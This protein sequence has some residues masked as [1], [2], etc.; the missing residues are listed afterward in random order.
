MNQIYSLAHRIIYLLQRT[1]CLYGN[2]VEPSDVRP[3]PPVNVYCMVC[4]KYLYT[5]YDSKV[6][7]VLQ[8][9]QLELWNRK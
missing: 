4:D 3:Y 7:R 1:E 5:E 2:H 8:D 9:R 6:N